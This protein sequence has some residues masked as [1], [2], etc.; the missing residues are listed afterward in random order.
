LES[1]GGAAAT[2]AQLSYSNAAAVAPTGSIWIADYGNNVIRAVAPN[3]TIATTAGIAGA[4]GFSGMADRP[5][6]RGS[7][8]RRASARRQT[9]DI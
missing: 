3:R 5:P 4:G 9:V 6:P 1:G 2:A 7:T 8:T